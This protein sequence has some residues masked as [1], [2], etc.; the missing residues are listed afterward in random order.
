MAAGPAGKIIN[1]GTN[2]KIVHIL[3]RSDHGG[4]VTRV[5]SLVRGHGGQ[6]PVDI[7]Q[8]TDSEGQ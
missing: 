4:P 2:S 1:K 7:A 5:G 3:S 6:P 8:G